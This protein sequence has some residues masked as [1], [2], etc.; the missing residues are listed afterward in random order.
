MHT[1]FLRKETREYTKLPNELL[2]RRG[3]SGLAKAILFMMLSHKDGWKMTMAQIEQCFTEGHKAVVNA[4]H[5]LELSGHAKMERIYD[6]KLK[7]P[8][9]VKWSWFSNP[10]LS[11]EIVKRKWKSKAP[12]VKS[13]SGEKSLKS[14]ESSVSDRRITIPSRRLSKEEDTVMKE[15]VSE[16]AMPTN[17]RKS[18][19]MKSFSEESLDQMPI[20]QF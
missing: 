17:G 18:A 11:K 4:I 7:R 12:L 1:I 16:E 10:D 9:G 15:E 6:H 20:Q 8:N 2:R 14:K 19:W 13:D 3:M 5:E